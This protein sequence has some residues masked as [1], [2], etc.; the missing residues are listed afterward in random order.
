MKRANRPHRKE[1]RHE[2]AELRRLAYEALAP[3]DKQAKSQAWPK[4]WKAK[5]SKKTCT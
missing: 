5:R 1:Q 2:E 3:E 4:P